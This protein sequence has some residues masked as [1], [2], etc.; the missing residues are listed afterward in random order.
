LELGG[1]VPVV[2]GV[3]ERGIVLLCHLR[4]AAQNVVVLGI[5]ALVEGP[6]GP[7]GP[8]C[9][10]AAGRWFVLI[11]EEGLVPPINTNSSDIRLR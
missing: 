1:A 2:N 4:V 10:E 11:C 7:A 5:L 6:V 3:A 9:I 8:A